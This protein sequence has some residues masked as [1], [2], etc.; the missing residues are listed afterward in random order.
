MAI[1]EYG[2]RIHLPVVTFSLGSYWE[3]HCRSR[4]FFHEREQ[5]VS[6]VHIEGS[7]GGPAPS[8]H[9]RSAR[10]AAP[11]LQSQQAQPRQYVGQSQ[12]SQ[13]Q[14]QPAPR[15]ASPA[16]RNAPQ[17]ERGLC[18]KRTCKRGS[19]IS[20]RLSDVRRHN[21]RNLRKPNL[22]LRLVHTTHNHH[23]AASNRDH[24]ESRQ[25]RNNRSGRNSALRKRRRASPLA[26]RKASAKL[27]NLRERN[28]GR[29]R[30]ARR[31]QSSA[32]T[33]VPS[34]NANPRDSSNLVTRGLSASG[35]GPRNSLKAVVRR[36]RRSRQLRPTGAAHL[37]GN[38]TG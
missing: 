15:T 22:A 35:E 25:R 27:S 21:R 32:R 26:V 2:P 17:G 6:R 1:I 20:L 3:Q 33:I 12:Q 29:N 34:E 5:W 30:I 7:H 23:R 37:L 36:E 8:R 14:P 19:A 9:E 13:M 11:S 24:S 10:Q 38:V 4:P 28:P 16:E 18:G 31:K